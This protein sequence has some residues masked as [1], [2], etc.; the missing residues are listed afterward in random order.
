MRLFII[1]IK[2]GPPTHLKPSVGIRTN[3]STAPRVVWRPK[4]RVSF[5]NVM[6][7]SW[8]VHPGFFWCCANYKESPSSLL[9]VIVTITPHISSNWPTHQDECTG[10]SFPP[11]ELVKGYSWKGLGEACAAVF[12]RSASEPTSL[13]RDSVPVILFFQNHALTRPRV[14]FGKRTIL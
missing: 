12:S 14:F 8:P 3:I 13:A 10:Q 4:S 9:T 6:L 7:L 5:P 11:Q 1:R 2:Q